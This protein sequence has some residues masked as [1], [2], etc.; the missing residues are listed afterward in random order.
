M[1]QL[2]NFENYGNPMVI[3]TVIPMVEQGGEIIELTDRILGD[4]KVLLA[5]K[6]VVEESYRTEMVDVSK[7]ISGYLIF[8]RIIV[9]L[10]A[11][12][13][14]IFTVRAIVGPIN[15]FKNILHTMAKGIFPE[16]KMKVRS[17]EIGEMSNALNLL[18]DGLKETLNFSLQIGKR[19][20]STNFKPLSEDDALGNALIQMSKDLQ[21]AAKDDEIRKKED[22]ERHWV[23]QGLAKFSEILRNNNGDLND[24]SYE[25]VSQLVRYLDA[26]QGGLFTVDDDEEKSK[27][28]ELLGAYAYN[29]KKLVEKKVDIG[30]GLVGTEVY[31]IRGI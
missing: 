23:S 17:D 18:V 12:G 3:Y 20:F 25:V 7:R 21:K 4:I 14:S 5:K 1:E 6:K 16:K 11:I 15:R 24:L 31:H 26:N 8:V 29:R 9:I 22:G 2:N 30:E 13:I 27:Q 19:N 28:L 10:I